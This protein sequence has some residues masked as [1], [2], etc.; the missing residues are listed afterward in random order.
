L[1]PTI[2]LLTFPHRLGRPENPLYFFL[3]GFTPRYDWDYLPTDCMGNPHGP[4]DTVRAELLF[5]LA[6][7]LFIFSIAMFGVC[8]LAAVLT[9]VRVARARHPPRLALWTLLTAVPSVL[10]WAEFWRSGLVVM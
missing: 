2:G 10:A 1:A 9:S 3:G 7:D 6:E 5:G 8:L 4:T